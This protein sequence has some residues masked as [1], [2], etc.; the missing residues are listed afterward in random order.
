MSESVT[1]PTH[2]EYGSKSFTAILW[3][4]FFAGFA[5][6]S[7]LYCVQ[8]MMPIFAKFFQVTPTHSSF[9]LSFFYRRLSNW[10][11]IHRFYF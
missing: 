5:S 2:I 4:L 10:S 8:P 1:R 7:S 6:F 11:V 3:S 9:P